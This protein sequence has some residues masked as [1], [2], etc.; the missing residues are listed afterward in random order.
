MTEKI[1]NQKPTA[2]FV[3]PYEQTKGNEAIELYEKCGRKAQE[4]QQ[5]L[6]ADILAFNDDGLWYI[7]NMAILSPGGRKT[8]AEFKT[9]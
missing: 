2:S 5:L 8:R 4:W 1:G 3:L 9:R 7:Q 6:I